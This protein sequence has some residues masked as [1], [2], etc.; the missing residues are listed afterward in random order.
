MRCDRTLVYQKITER[1]S[2]KHDNLS[3]IF[4][5][6]WMKDAISKH[7]EELEDLAH[8]DKL[9]DRYI[10]GK[11]TMLTFS[12]SKVLQTAA[13]DEFD[14]YIHDDFAK[15]VWGEVG[16]SGLIYGQLLYAAAPMFW[17]AFDV[18][19]AMA[20]SK[21]TSPVWMWFLV[22]LSVAVFLVFPTFFCLLFPILAFV[23]RHKAK[24]LMAT[25]LANALGCLAAPSILGLVLF[26]G[27]YLNGFLKQRLPFIAFVCILVLF[28]VWYFTRFSLCHNSFRG[29]RK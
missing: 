13:V 2:L 10:T 27:R 14:E 23:E 8:L 4:E 26:L 25:V 1:F 18:V 5:S 22:E 11:N 29:N 16:R 19:A 21:A 7:S 17:H 3:S 28:N 9:K 12:K 20:S 24:G 15:H 6:R